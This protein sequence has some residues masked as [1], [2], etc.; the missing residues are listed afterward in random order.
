MIRRFNAWAEARSQ[1]AVASTWRAGNGLPV[2]RCSAAGLLGLVLVAGACTGLNQATEDANVDTPPPD[3][4]SCELS[5]CEHLG[6]DCGEVDDGC[7]GTVLCGTCRP[8]DFCGGG[9]EL[10]V[11][12]CTPT[13]CALEDR[14]CGRIE[15]GCGGM[16]ECGD[17]CPDYVLSL[18]I[19]APTDSKAA[20]VAIGDVTGDGLDDLV[21]VTTRTIDHPD[22]LSVFV[23][24]QRPGMFLADP[25]VYPYQYVADC[26]LVGCVPAQNGLALADLDADGDLDVVVGRARQSCAAW[27]S[28]A[29]G[30][31]TL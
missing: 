15:D 11:C 31:L 29:T 13:T 16:L 26:S 19:V 9:G 22:D 25:L 5:T 27:T 8:P 23:Y 1:V 21:M 28:T 20:A 4:A 17:E 12:G 18:P 7:G 14:G 30:T 2:S 6:S 3:S 10:N 24:E